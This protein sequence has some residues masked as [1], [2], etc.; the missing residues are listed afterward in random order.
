MKKIFICLI[1]LMP[2]ISFC[3]KPVYS[4]GMD[5]T[6]HIASYMTWFVEKL[7][8]ANEAETEQ[9][10]DRT[11]VLINNYVAE[12]KN[13]KSNTKGLSLT[14]NMFKNVL[15][16]SKKTF[17]MSLSDWE[18][19]IS[20]YVDDTANRRSK[21]IIN[22]LANDF[23]IQFNY[24]E[25]SFETGPLPFNLIDVVK[26]EVKDKEI[27]SFILENTNYKILIRDKK[28]NLRYKSQKEIASLVYNL[29]A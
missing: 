25:A 3:E 23:L 19:L 27:Y 9:Y 11:K 13:V 10:K 4:S 8:N 24:S 7:Q 1:L 17:D 20:P 12:I 29:A 18:Y 15:A 2:S 5:K 6:E 28:W 22:K 14:D 26:E 21:A 16:L